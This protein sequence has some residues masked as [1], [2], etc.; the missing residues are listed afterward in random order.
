MAPTGREEMLLELVRETRDD[1]KRVV[2]KI[3]GHAERIR[4]VE[5]VQDAHAAKLSEFTER[6]NRVRL[7]TW[8]A[9][10]AAVAAVLSAIL[11]WVHI[12]PPTGNHP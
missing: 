4:D 2:E 7:A 5:A 8:S 11:K 10:S 6:D 9:I 12:T 1:V 3:D